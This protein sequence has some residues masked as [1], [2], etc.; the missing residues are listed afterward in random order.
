MK[1]AIR[2]MAICVLLITAASAKDVFVS[3]PVGELKLTA[4]EMPELEVYRW[5]M[6]ESPRVTLEAGEAFLMVPPR[7]NELPPPDQPRP[8]WQY[9]FVA[10]VPAGKAVGGWIVFPKMGDQEARVVKFKLPAANGS[11]Q[12]AELNFQR[13]REQYYN[14][15][16]GNDMP[17]AAWFRHQAA[18]AHEARVKLHDPSA[19]ARNSDE[20]DELIGMRRGMRQRGI[21]DTYSLMSGGRAVSENLRLDRELMVRGGNEAIMPVSAIKG[22]SVRP[23]A[24]DT[25]LSGTAPTLDP[26]AAA[27]PDDQHAIFFPTF[28]AM[29]D[30]MDEADR[31]GTPILDLLEPRSEDAR[32]RERYQKQLCLATDAL[33]RMLGPALVRSVAFTGSDPYLRTGSDVA[34]L[35]EADAAAVAALIGARQAAAAQAN[36][37]ARPVQGEI[38]G[39][40]YSG[41]RTPDR[42][43]CTYLASSGNVVVVSNSPYQIERIIKTIKGKTTPL[44]NAKEYA[45]FRSRYGRGADE[46]ALIVLTDNTIRRWCGPQWRI[47]NSR[48]VRM[49]SAMNEMQAR[50]IERLA[51][52]DKTTNTLTRGLIGVDDVTWTDAGPISAKYGTLEFQTPI[53]E[54]NIDRAT[55]S[56]ADTYARFRDM[57]EMQWSRFFDPIAIRLSVAP[58]R[59]GADLTVMPL[60]LGTD[61]REFT[62]LTRGAR[63]KP[64]AGD[65]HPESVLHFVMAINRQS[66][67]IR[68]LGGMLSQQTGSQ[69]TNPLGWLGSSIAIYAD[70]DPF[71]QAMAQAKQGEDFA[72]KNMGRIPVAATFEVTDGLKL[73]AFLTALHGF[74]DQSAPGMSR[75]TTLDHKGKPYVRI[76]ATPSADETE[77]GTMPWSIY[78]AATPKSLT[79]T[80]NEALLK[81]ALDRQAA[82]PAAAATDWQGQSLALNARK[83]ALDVVNAAGSES[84]QK[85]MQERSWAN[86]P[87]L[88]EWRKMFPGE[89][90]AAVH[91]RLWGVRLVDPAGGQYTWNDEWKTMESSVY[92]NPAAARLGSGMPEALTRINSLAMGVTFENDG[93]RARANINRAPKP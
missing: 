79:V 41:F 47:G 90:P 18:V 71:W 50:R 16:A 9:T 72:E 10:R 8:R 31:N 1:A 27:I 67:A 73:A 85:T 13:A 7:S 38:E 58:G 43:I 59:L 28:Q 21:E 22:I 54:L 84:Y 89:D 19:T 56:E 65:P 3:I 74:A 68:E 69:L 49:A 60:V 42:S 78:Y 14:G 70:A 24:W 26:L 46:S 51:A 29:V 57:Y 52:N 76:S 61:Y 11:A 45:F 4:G 25:L 15:L 30:V 66:S 62:D 88:N 2:A 77:T 37:A 17:G 64:G 33:S 63:I 34:I 80:L 36:P 91:E 6:G 75:W 48:R 81:R 87:I 39:V 12:G 20:M 23:F 82:R 35:F 44:G 40:K 53:A 92:G 32:T 83:G 5:M 86:L 93:L 55:R